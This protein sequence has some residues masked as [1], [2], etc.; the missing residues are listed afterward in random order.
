MFVGDSISLNQWQSLGCMLHAAVPNART[1]YTRKEALSTIAFEVPFFLSETSAIS[2]SL[3]F[4]SPASSSTLLPLP[5]SPNCYESLFCFVEIQDLKHHIRWHMWW[6][7]PIVHVSVSKKESH[8]SYPGRPQQQG[9]S[10]H[11]ESC[12]PHQLPKLAFPALLSREVMTELRDA[13]FRF[14]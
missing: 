7:C 14:L 2:P 13:P 6:W 5:C 9:M 12:F 10:L 8:S 11:C 4:S 3:F 1:T